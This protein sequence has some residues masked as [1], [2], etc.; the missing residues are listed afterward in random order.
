M[1]RIDKTTKIV[2]KT[3]I[4]LCKRRCASNGFTDDG[5]DVNEG[6]FVSTCEGLECIL[7]PCLEFEKINLSILLKQ[8]PKLLECLQS[9]INYLISRVKISDKGDEF[10]FPGDPYLRIGRVRNSTNQLPNLDSAAF[11]VSTML[12]LKTVIEREN[13]SK[14]KF[15]IS[16]M[17]DLIKHGLSQI[18][19]S[20]IPNKGWPWARGGEE[21]HMYFTWSVLE[22]LNDAFE[23]DPD[24]KLFDKYDSLKDAMDDTRIWIEK[25]ML[26]NMAEGK[27]VGK[28]ITQTY[29]YIEALISLTILGT[30]KYLE[31]ADFLN[32]LL[33]FCEK[34]AEKPLSAEYHIENKPTTLTDYSII[35]LL[36]RGITAAFLEFGSNEKFKKRTSS[37]KYRKVIKGR[38]DALNK[39][40]TKEDL[41][42]YDAKNYELYFTERAIEALIMHYNYKYERKKKKL[43]IKTFKKMR[44]DL[45]EMHKTK[46]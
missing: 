4:A 32:H 7:L 2:T 22:T 30:N 12:N 13:I 33:P 35:P 25:N 24:E 11:I 38:F 28:D 18:N 8:F 17:N 45:E 9:D 20:H 46:G 40:R 5:G 44:R 3:I 37:I 16:E 1:D 29:L 10:V 27:D 39:K 26:N 31:I 36:L 15:P 14:E 41:W 6:A 34:I 19:D 23:Y 21:T 43:P 42:A